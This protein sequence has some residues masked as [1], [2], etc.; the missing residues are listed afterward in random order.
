MTGTPLTLNT[1]AIKG[2]AS[3]YII[4]TM[5]TFDDVTGAPEWSSR[6]VAI[7]SAILLGGIRMVM[8][9]KFGVNWY[10]LVHA[11][12]TGLGS[13]ACVWLDVFAAEP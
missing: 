5:H 6:H 10:S 7:V 8:K 1:E 2:S 9:Q 12:I 3:Y 4:A 13:F 11:F